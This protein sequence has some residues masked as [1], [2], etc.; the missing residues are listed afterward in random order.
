M[1]LLQHSF[2]Q[3]PSTVGANTEQFT[4]AVAREADVVMTSIRTCAQIAS[5]WN[6]ISEKLPDS[7]QTSVDTHFVRVRTTC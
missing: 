2:S 3:G 1:T 7:N 6:G 4:R 5:D